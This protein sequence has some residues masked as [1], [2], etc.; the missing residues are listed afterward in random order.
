MTKA[1]WA[2]NLILNSDKQYSVEFYEVEDKVIVKEI[3]LDTPVASTQTN[4]FDLLKALLIK[5]RKL[6]N[7]ENI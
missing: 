2:A 5:I 6:N 3:E 4:K 7:D 1:Q